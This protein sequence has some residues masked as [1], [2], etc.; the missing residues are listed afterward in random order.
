[1]HLVHVFV[2][3]KQGLSAI[4]DLH[5]A[6]RLQFS[7]EELKNENRSLGSCRRGQGQNSALQQYN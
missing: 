3:W 2:K 7:S 1:M 6:V 4:R 5:G